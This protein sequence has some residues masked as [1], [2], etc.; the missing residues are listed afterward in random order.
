MPIARPG[1]VVVRVLA[2]GVCRTDLH[3]VDGELPDVATMPDR[4]PATRSS[5]SS[6]SSATASRAS[7]SAIASAFRGSATRAGPCAFCRTGRENLCPAARASP[8]IQLDGGYADYTVA[9]AGYAFK[10]PDV[11]CDVD[12]APLLCAGLI[13]YRA[14]RM[15][16]EAE[17]ARP[18][19]LRRGG[20]H[21]RAG[22]A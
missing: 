6:S 21:H 14:Y 1:D 22:R 12:A 17:A 13:G 19:R 15:A 10:L 11:Y 2:C 7:R 3:I 20:A 16:G 18:V 8:A 9:D 4:V 5:A